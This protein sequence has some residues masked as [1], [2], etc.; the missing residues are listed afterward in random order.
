[1]AY[2]PKSDL[3]ALATAHRL[4]RFH[5]I[6][7]LYRKVTIS[8]GVHPRVY[9]KAKGLVEAPH[10]LKWISTLAFEAHR[11]SHVPSNTGIFNNFFT[12]FSKM[13]N[14]RELRLE[15]IHLDAYAQMVILETPLLSLACYGCQFTGEQLTPALACHSSVNVL[16]LTLEKDPDFPNSVPPFLTH[17]PNVKTLDLTVLQR[18]YVC[19]PNFPSLTT[20]S[21]QSPIALGTLRI[22]LRQSPHLAQLRC[23]QRDLKDRD[24]TPTKIPRLQHIEA[25]TPA[26]IQLLQSP[27]LKSIVILTR[28]GYDDNHWNTVNRLLLAIQSGPAQQITSLDITVW[29]QEKGQATDL[30]VKLSSAVPNLSTFTL[31]VDPFGIDEILASPLYNGSARLPKLE[32]L[33]ISIMLTGNAFSQPCVIPEDIVQS[34]AEVF[35]DT[36]VRPICPSLHVVRVVSWYSSF[37]KTVF[38]GEGTTWEFERHR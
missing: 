21:I 4:I 18:D 3:K 30:L 25:P 13:T 29:F 8:T 38:E 20:L 26:V 10:I 6:P 12:S 23:L 27:E 35:L 22:I 31:R 34:F 33:T 15:R 5:A 28:R 16:R 1:M 36:L 24:G 19:F 14:L 7:L 17:F 37:A 2:L 11:N 32:S 9:E